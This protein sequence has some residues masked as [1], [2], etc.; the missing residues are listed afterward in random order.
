MP[1]FQHSWA[2]FLHAPL[3]SSAHHFIPSPTP[4]APSPPFS[5][6]A[7][8]CPPRCQRWVPSG[9]L[10]RRG[11]AF[12]MDATGCL[13]LSHSMGRRAISGG[14]LSPPYTTLARVWHI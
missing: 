5:H 12:T 9:S 10:G 4:Q 6:A 7:E 11:S 13:A 14:L 1:V 3:I 8:P 2:A